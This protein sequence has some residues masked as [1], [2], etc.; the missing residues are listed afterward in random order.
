[1]TAI[2]HWERAIHIA[3]FALVGIAWATAIVG[4]ASAARRAPGRA[5]GLA[6]RFPVHVVYLLGAVPYFLICALL[7]RPLPVEPAST[8]MR[9]VVLVAGT[10][11]GLAGA[12]LYLG[13]RRTLG[14]MYN[15]SSSLG[16]ELYADQYLIESGPYALVR[17]PM[18]LGL[19]LA[20]AGGLLV[21]RTWTL[22][23][24]AATLIGAVIKA[25]HEEALLAAEFGDHWID[26]SSRVPGWIPRLTRSDHEE[27]TDDRIT[28]SG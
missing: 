4:A 17:H 6:T 25:H 18:Y 13:G 8:A 12:A 27:V 26:Y 7:W 5:T 28:T 14:A 10:G 1:M 11:L 22:V 2:E 19:M 3:G 20:A 9:T 15:V 16:C 21:Y 23:F 24:M